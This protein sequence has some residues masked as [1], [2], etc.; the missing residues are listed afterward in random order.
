MNRLNVVSLG[1]HC[2]PAWLLRRLGLRD[3]AMP[4]DWLFSDPGMVA[5]CLLDD[6]SD[7]LDEAKLVRVDPWPGRRVGHRVYSPKYRR[8]VIFQHHD[9]TDAAGRAYLLRGLDRFR[10]LLDAGDPTLFL[11]IGRPDRITPTALRSLGDAMALRTRN[12]ALLAVSVGPAKVSAMRPHVAPDPSA[13]LCYRLTPTSEMQG[14]LSFRNPADNA[15]IQAL[16][17]RHIAD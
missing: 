12:A 10:R 2:Y 11:L 14:G 3:A 8:P 16:I 7:F 17:E 6:F 5:D 9:P 1:A 13:S 15:A 4:F